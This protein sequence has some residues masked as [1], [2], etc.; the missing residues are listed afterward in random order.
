MFDEL[1]EKWEDLM[2]WFKQKFNNPNDKRT[3]KEKFND[4]KKQV[5][6]LTSEDL[7]DWAEEKFNILMVVLFLFVAW[8]LY[9]CYTLYVPFKQNLLNSEIQKVNTKVLEVAKAEKLKQEKNIL[10]ISE[11]VIVPK[12]YNISD[13]VCYMTKFDKEHIPYVNKDFKLWKIGIDEE[14][15]NFSTEIEGIKYYKSI[16]DLLVLLK[17]YK[18]LFNVNEFQVNLVDDESNWPWVSYYNVAINGKIVADELPNVE[19]DIEA[20]TQ[21]S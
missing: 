8:I 19:W 12:K 9:W 1:K 17:N 14:E 6:S 2:D 5:Q 3:T 20:W 15:Q 10:S 4:F 18:T 16:T 13:F 21:E 7:N 11:E